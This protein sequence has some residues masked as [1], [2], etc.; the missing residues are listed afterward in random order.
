MKFLSVLSSGVSYAVSSGDGPAIAELQINIKAVEIDALI[1]A[2]LLVY[3]IPTLAKQ[4]A[5]K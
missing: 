2:R 1:K 4:I 3:S 5:I